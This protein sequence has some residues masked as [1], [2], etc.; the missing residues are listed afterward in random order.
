MLRRASTKF[1]S[2]VDTYKQ[3]TAPIRWSASGAMFCEIIGPYAHVAV[4]DHPAFYFPSLARRA[5]LATLSLD[6][7]QM[8]RQCFRRRR[9]HF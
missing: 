4:A 8:D 3:V 2:P 1:V 7:R 9:R 5:S 6:N